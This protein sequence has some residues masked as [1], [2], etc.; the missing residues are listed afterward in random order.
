MSPLYVNVMVLWDPYSLE[1]KKV[2]CMALHYVSICSAVTK[3]KGLHFS[4]YL[5]NSN[6]IHTV[7]LQFWP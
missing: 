5:Q 3:P 1:S 6:K 4:A 2:V 7:Q